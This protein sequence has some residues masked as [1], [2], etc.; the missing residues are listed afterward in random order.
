MNRKY[1]I[2]EKHFDESKL[3][4]AQKQASTESAFKYVLVL[5]KESNDS[6]FINELAKIASILLVTSAQSE[7][8]ASALKRRD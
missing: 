5:N 6:L 1:G 3:K 4:F 8:G 2:F 7:Q